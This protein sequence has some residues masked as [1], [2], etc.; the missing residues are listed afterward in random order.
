[1]ASSLANAAARLA[2]LAEASRSTWSAVISPAANAAAV[3]GIAVRARAW[4]TR[5]SAAALRIPVSRDSRAP[6][7]FEPLSAHTWRVSQVWTSWHQAARSRLVWRARSM[8]ASCSSSSDRAVDV[9]VEQFVECCGEVLGDH[10]Q[11]SY[12][13]CVRL[14]TSVDG[15]LF[16]LIGRSTTFSAL[17]QEP[18]TDGSQRL[19][20]LVAAD[21]SRPRRASDNAC[22]AMPNE[23]TLP[24]TC[25]TQHVAAVRSADDVA[26]RHG[27]VA[28]PNLADVLDRVLDTG[29]IIAAGMRHQRRHSGSVSM[30]GHVERATYTYAIARPFHPSHLWGVR[31]VDRTA[32]HLVHHGELVAVVGTLS[33]T[34]AD[35]AALRARLETPAELEAIARAH[36]A[37]VNAVFEHSVT[38]PFRLATIHQSEQRVVEMLRTGHE[39]FCSALAQLDGRVEV[40]VTIYS[41]VVASPRQPESAPR[42]LGCPSTTGTTVRRT[43]A[44]PA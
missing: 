23:S 33:F 18:E 15:F 16:R 21:S 3:W 13:T 1:M 41:D 32:V 8:T 20:S 12:R 14:A 31:G 9:E 4:W 30:N 37:V 11:P 38:L 24:S 39:R 44:C 5:W 35:E 29:T 2:V 10:A 17:K 7:A 28:A 36:H 43:L 6:G 26:G 27:S 34:E 22:E 25:P 19:N 42:W 40:G